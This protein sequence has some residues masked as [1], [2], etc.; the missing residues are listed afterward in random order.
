MTFSRLDSLYGCVSTFL[1]LAATHHELRCQLAR[2]ADNIR[3]LPGSLI[4][5]HLQPRTT[6]AAPPP[7][8]RLGGCGGVASILGEPQPAT[9]M[10]L[11]TLESS[12]DLELARADAAA[13]ALGHKLLRGRSASP[14]RP[15][16]RYE[17]PQKGEIRRWSIAH[18]K[19]YQGMK[20][21]QTR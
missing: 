14:E 3:L 11:G 7:I 9:Q 12:N 2:G 17:R 4:G 13:T 15:S 8:P 1:S 21:E 6:T 16:S 10:P 19:W 18:G 5:T 20:Q